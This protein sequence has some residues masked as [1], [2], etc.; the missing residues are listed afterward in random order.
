MYYHQTLLIV[1]GDITDSSIYEFKIKTK[2]VF[3]FFNTQF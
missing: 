3:S 2:S 1:T